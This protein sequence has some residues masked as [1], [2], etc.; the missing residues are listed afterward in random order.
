MRSERKREEEGRESL[1]REKRKEQ[2]RRRK[3]RPPLQLRAAT[4]SCCSSH[5]RAVHH[6]CEEAQNRGREPCAEKEA[7]P[8]VEPALLSS[9]LRSSRRCS[10]PLPSRRRCRSDQRRRGKRDQNGMEGKE[11]TFAAVEP[12]PP[13]LSSETATETSVFLVSSSHVLVYLPYPSKSVT[14]RVVA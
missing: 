2:W 8:S 4:P 6:H 11:A 13:L 3:G 12:S 7:S 1:R 10:S 5:H 14:V 9:P